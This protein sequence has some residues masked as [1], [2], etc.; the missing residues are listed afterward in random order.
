[1][2]ARSLVGIGIGIGVLVAVCTAVAVVDKTALA[3]TKSGTIGV[4]M[5]NIKGPCFRRY[6]SASAMKPRS[7][8]MT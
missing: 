7:S 6:S 5:P 1:M 3:D 2:R 4:S 8:A